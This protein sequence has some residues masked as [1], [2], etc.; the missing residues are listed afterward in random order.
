MNRQIYANEEKINHV[1]FSRE[2]KNW[3][4]P[5]RFQ[6]TSAGTF[7]LQNTTVLTKPQIVALF[8]LPVLEVV[9]VYSSPAKNFAFF[10]KFSYFEV[11]I[12]SWYKISEPYGMPHNYPTMPKIQIFAY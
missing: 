1:Y 4:D 8:S 11:E 7:N 3:Q 9:H 6:Q 5:V 12:P 2:R 10:T